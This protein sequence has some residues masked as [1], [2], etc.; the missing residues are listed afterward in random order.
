VDVACLE[1]VVNALFDEVA[2]G[3]LAELKPDT[4]SPAAV[5]RSVLEGW[6]TLIDKAPQDQLS[7]EA[8]VGL[9]GELH[10]LHKLAQINPDCLSV[11]TGP[12]VPPGRHDFRRDDYSLEIKT[13]TTRRGRSCEIHGLLQLEPPPGG[14]LALCFVRVELAEAGRSV[15][16]LIDEII[17][18]GV[19]RIAL[20]EKLALL[21]Y[22]TIHEPDYRSIRF[23]ILEE[24]PYIVGPDFPRIVATS[25]AGGQL[26]PGVNY[27][28]YGIDLS[29]APPF[30]MATQDFSQLL[31]SLAMTS[32]GS[33]P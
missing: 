18:A 13:T 20:L 30:P 15:P 17:S 16:A 2:A 3:M 7:R 31:H 10:F 8:L 25:F 9:F 23:S 29:M 11:W 19:P 1:P 4:N 27:V 32:V 22:S 24:H 5:C 33:A 6:R 26:P 28:N 14:T 12:G 21:K